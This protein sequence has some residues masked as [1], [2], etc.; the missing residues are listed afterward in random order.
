[1]NVK[2]GQSVAR[3]AYPYCGCT[4]QLGAY[5]PVWQ[6]D[7]SRVGYAFGYADLLVKK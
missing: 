5:N 4:D 3:V 6:R 2:A 1:M 7:G